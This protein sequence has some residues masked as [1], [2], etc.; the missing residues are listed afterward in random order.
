MFE[1][2]APYQWITSKFT[3]AYRAVGTVG[4]GF[5]HPTDIENVP[6]IP[7]WRIDYIFYDEHFRGLDARTLERTG[8][9]D[10]LPLLARLQITQ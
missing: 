1:Q 9:T 10:H 5:T 6:S 7:F 2:F 4:L 8:S 3:D